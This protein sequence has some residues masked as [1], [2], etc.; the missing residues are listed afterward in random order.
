MY[1]VHREL[2]FQSESYTIGCHAENLPANT[3]WLWQILVYSMGRYKEAFL[4]GRGFELSSWRST[5]LERN[6]DF[7]AQNVY[8]RYVDVSGVVEVSWIKFRAFPFDNIRMGIVIADGPTQPP[9]NDAS[10]K[11]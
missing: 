3:Q 7:Q 6:S 5:A 9:D 2:S 4:E 1:N 8:S 11:D 10:H